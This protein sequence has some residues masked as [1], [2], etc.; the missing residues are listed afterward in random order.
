[1]NINFKNNILINLNLNYD[2]LI[3][4]R[5]RLLFKRFHSLDNG[6]LHCFHIKAISLYINTYVINLKQ[7]FNH[8]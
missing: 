5:R 6:Y 7:F 2:H 3:Y 8:L 4:N 1:M